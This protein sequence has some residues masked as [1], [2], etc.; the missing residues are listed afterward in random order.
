M[1]SK[2]TTTAPRPSDRAAERADYAAWKLAAVAEL[3]NR[4]IV[5]AGTIPERLWKSS[6]TSASSKEAAV[7][8]NTKVRGQ[9]SARA[10]IDDGGDASSVSTNSGVGLSAEIRLQISPCLPA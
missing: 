4:H 7:L 2:R 6:I 3:A 10:S 8:Q 1:P 5:K 9:T